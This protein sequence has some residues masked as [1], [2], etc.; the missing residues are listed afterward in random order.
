MMWV[1][2]FNNFFNYILTALRKMLTERGRVAIHVS[3]D[4]NDLVHFLVLDTGIGIP[5]DKRDCLFK[6][7][8]QVDDSCVSHASCL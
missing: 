6:S 7:F 3:S 5:D 2:Q 1:I 8:R 4:T